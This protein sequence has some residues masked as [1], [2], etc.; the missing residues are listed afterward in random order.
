MAYRI[1]LSHGAPG[2]RIDTTSWQ[3][4]KALIRVFDVEVGEAKVMVDAAE[5]GAID[6]AVRAALGQ[7][8][9]SLR[10][11]GGV[12]VVGNLRASLFGLAGRMAVDAE[13]FRQVHDANK[14]AALAIAAAHLYTATK[15]G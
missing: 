11:C 14:A 15:D 1:N 4:D 7:E 13:A 5:W 3:Q 9:D 2:D 12:D 8:T 10:N 6:A